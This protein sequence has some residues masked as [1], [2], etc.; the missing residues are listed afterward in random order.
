MFLFWL[1][2]IDGTKDSAEV[3]DWIDISAYRMADLTTDLFAEH[4]PE[5]MDCP[6]NGFRVE[7]NQLEIQTDICNY[8]VV[9]W[10]TQYDLP[11]NTT[12]E[13]LVLHTGLWAPEEGNAHFAL[14]IDGVLFWE[15]FPPIP[16]DTEFFFYEQVWPSAI[17][18][19]TTVQLHLH[20]HGANDWKIG[21]FQPTSQ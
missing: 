19:G 12:L 13:A 3:V 8:A 15:E 16:S 20:N 17:P 10:Q 14:S 1:A 6:A 18:T 11:T 21:Y 2:C 4:Q 7:I 9:E 5:E